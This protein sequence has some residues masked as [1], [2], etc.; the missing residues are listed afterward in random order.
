MMN[1]LFI[2]FMIKLIAQ[3]NVYKRYDIEILSIDVGLNKEHLLKITE[4][5]YAKS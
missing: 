5:M 1:L 4:K 2:L 3:I